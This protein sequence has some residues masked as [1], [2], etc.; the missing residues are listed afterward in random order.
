MRVWTTIGREYAVAVALGFAP[1]E[2]L[3]FTRNAVS[4]AFVPGERRAALLGE[5]DTWE[6]RHAHEL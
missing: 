4:A 5:L 3:G 2:L 1:A 6:A